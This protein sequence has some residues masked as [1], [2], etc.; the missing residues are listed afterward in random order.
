MDPDAPKPSVSRQFL[1]QSHAR[2]FEN[3]RKWV[4][5]KTDADP[6]FFEKL[7]A[8]QTPEYL[9]VPSGRYHLLLTQ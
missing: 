3:N 1:E 7:A 9:Y 2:I 6:A 5:G 8:G 4:A